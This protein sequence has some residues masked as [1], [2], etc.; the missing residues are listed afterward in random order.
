MNRFVF[1]YF[2]YLLKVMF[3]V[4]DRKHQEEWLTVLDHLVQMMKQQYR[5]STFP[6]AVTMARKRL[7]LAEFTDLLIVKK[8]AE[9]FLLTS[10]AQIRD[11]LAHL[12]VDSLSHQ[13][14]NILLVIY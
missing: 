5:C 10:S 8:A 11:C 9:S 6:L 13:E 2:F 4:L 14:T 12:F 7:P 1:C 3:G